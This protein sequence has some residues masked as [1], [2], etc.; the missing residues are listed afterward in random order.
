[1]IRR[2]LALVG[3]LMHRALPKIVVA[4][5]LAFA[6]VSTS[7]KAQAQVTFLPH[8]PS[9]PTNPNCIHTVPNGAALN[10]QTGIVTL[11]GAFVAQFDDSACTS[12]AEPDITGSGGYYAQTSATIFPTNATLTDDFGGTFTVSSYPP[13]FFNGT[14]YWSF[15]PGIVAYGWPGLSGIGAVV[16][17][18]VLV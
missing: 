7:N 4:A 5:L 8:M 3:L 15:W 6:A 16:L 13:G 12:G 17:Q 18:P 2:V 14:E 10:V 11:N 1:M 9:R